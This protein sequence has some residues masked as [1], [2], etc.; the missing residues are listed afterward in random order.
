MRRL[1]LAL[2][3]GL[4]ATVEAETFIG[5]TSPTNRFLI[6]SNDAVLIRWFSTS[7]QGS[8]IHQGRLGGIY[9]HNPAPATGSMPDN[10]IVITGDSELIITNSVL[11]SMTRI[12]GSD[13]RS[14]WIEPDGPTNHVAVSANRSIRLLRSF[15]SAYSTDIFVANIGS[16]N[17]I[18]LDHLFYWEGT[19]LELDGPI[20]L[21]FQPKPN[22]GGGGGEFFVDL[23]SDHRSGPS[24]PTTRDHPRPH[25]GLPRPCGTLRRHDQLDDQCNHQPCGR[26]EAVLPIQNWQ[27]DHWAAVSSRPSDKTSSTENQKS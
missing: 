25:G 5:P 7:I 14:F 16:T 8:I 2:L 18:K 23:L 24:P 21:T 15:N 4:A 20:E 17:R 13:I 1:L 26:S 27:I 10:P 22:L 6:A 12:T 19:A 3:L 9:L 11:I